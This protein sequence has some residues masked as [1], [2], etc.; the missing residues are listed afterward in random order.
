ML[1]SKVKNCDLDETLVRWIHSEMKN[2]A[3]V[4]YTSIFKI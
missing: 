3:H 1:E 2:E 4:N